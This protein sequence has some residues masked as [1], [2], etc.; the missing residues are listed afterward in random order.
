[1]ISACIVEREGMRHTPAGVP[2]LNLRL[3][4]ASEIEEAGQIRQVKARI[5]AVAFG[6]MAETLAR[7]ELGSHWKFSGFLASPRDTKTVVFHVQQF[8]QDQ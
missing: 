8:L 5:K 4:H 6:A 1:M 3:E 2:A 7:K